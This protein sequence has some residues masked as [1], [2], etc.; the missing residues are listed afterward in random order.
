[1]GLLGFYFSCP[2]FDERLLARQPT[3]KV[4]AKDLDI[5][6]SYDIIHEYQKLTI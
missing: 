4:K 1:M 6:K 3:V 5:Y 2:V